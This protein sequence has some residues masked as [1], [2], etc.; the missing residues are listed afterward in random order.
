MLAWVVGSDAYREIPAWHRWRE[1]F[2]LTNLIVLQR[3]GTSM[4]LDPELQALTEERQVISI[5]HDPA[6]SVRILD[7]AMRDVSATAVRRA[8]AGS[9]GKV[10]GKRRVADLLPP[11]VYTYIMKY[12]LYGVVSDA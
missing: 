7:L 10:P 12:H 5:F 4:E 9:S 3:P 8:L 2:A 6:G 11:A 1:V